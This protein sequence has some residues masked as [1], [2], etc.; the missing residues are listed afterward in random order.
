MYIYIYVSQKKT[1]TF[2]DQNQIFISF[3]NFTFFPLKKKM[4]WPMLSCHLGTA[5]LV[6][7]A[8]AESSVCHGSSFRQN[9]YG[10][11]H[12][13][14]RPLSPKAGQQTTQS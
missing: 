3:P 2:V 9:A 8:H 5:A 14:V 1:A 4:R 6:N 12:S 11:K 13:W 7:L 10:V